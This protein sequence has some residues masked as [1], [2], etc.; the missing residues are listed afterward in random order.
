[1]SSVAIRTILP[2]QTT[3]SRVE[4]PLCTQRATE[5]LVEADTVISS[6]KKETT[7]E[8]FERLRVQ[9]PNYRLSL[10][11]E[12]KWHALEK[13]ASKGN[14]PLIRHIVNIGGR[15]LLE[16][17]G[18]ITP[19]H[20]A[21]WEGHLEAIQTLIECGAHIN[22]SRSTTTDENSSVFKQKAH[23]NP[24]LTFAKVMINGE[25]KIKIPKATQLDSA[26]RSYAMG[27]SRKISVVIYMIKEGGILNLDHPLSSAEK[28]LY[29]R[30][31]EQ[32]K[33]DKADLIARIFAVGAEFGLIHDLCL[34]IADYADG[35]K[36]PPPA[37]AAHLEEIPN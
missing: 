13:A 23:Y 2:L 25:Q 1:M 32:I 16:L 28:C 21:A 6:I 29:D 10:G 18:W 14:A 36:P 31:I 20:N 8:E 34:I 3:E 9:H 17:E 26:L 30:A 5:N 4:I 7:V 15:A 22:T 24:N 27:E 33:T 11:G 37:S 35:I 19:L 12:N